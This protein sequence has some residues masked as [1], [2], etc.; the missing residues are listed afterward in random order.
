MSLR[1]R[2][3]VTPDPV[4]VS[5]ILRQIGDC[6]SQPDA[7]GILSVPFDIAGEILTKSEAKREHETQ[8]IEGLRAGT[9]DRSWIDAK[10]GALGYNLSA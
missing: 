4:H 10:L 1:G 2:V 9:E 6:Q 7:D 5:T 3:A 8:H